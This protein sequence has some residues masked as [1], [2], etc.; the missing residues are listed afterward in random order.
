MFKGCCSLLQPL[1]CTFDGNLSKILSIKWIK[2]NIKVCLYTDLH[3]VQKRNK[4]DIIP[5]SE[6]K[7]LSL[8]KE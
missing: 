6:F 3:F 7:C 8:V 5:L 2:F 4:V 1:A